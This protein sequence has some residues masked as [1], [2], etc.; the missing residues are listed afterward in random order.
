MSLSLDSPTG[1]LRNNIDRAEQK[2]K[3]KEAGLCNCRHACSEIEN[4]RKQERI[5]DQQRQMRRMQPKPPA[6]GRWNHVHSE[7]RTK[8]IVGVVIMI[9]DRIFIE[10][11]IGEYGVAH[12]PI[13]GTKE[14]VELA[15]NKAERQC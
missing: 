7:R 4:R 10:N 11:Q 15:A 1:H 13:I 12:E 5:L 6:H 14:N 9:K 2:Q 8:E 3:K